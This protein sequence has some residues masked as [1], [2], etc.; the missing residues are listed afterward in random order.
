MK[1]TGIKDNLARSLNIVQH[2]L[3]S[4][5]IQPIL[6]GI[7]LS[8]KNGQLTMIATDI[9]D[10]VGMRIQCSVPINVIEEGDT[11]VEGKQF[12][13][14]VTRLPD[15]NII[16][17]ND[18]YNGKDTM[19][20][21]YGNN[22]VTMYGFPGYEF[23]NEPKMELTHHLAMSAQT[24]S[25]IVRQT[26]FAVKKEDLRPIFTGL[27]FEVI[28]NELTVVG[29]DSFRLALMK[30]KINNLTGE[31][32]QVVI[33]VRALQEVVSIAEEDAIINISIAKNQVIFEM[34]N[35]RLM[36]QLIKGEF[37]P[38]KGA[39]PNTHTTFFSIERATIKQSLERATL[40]SKDRTGT[41]VVRWIV[42]NGKVDIKTES[43]IGKVN[44]EIDVFIEGDAVNI[45]FNANFLMD[46]L[47]K[48][49]YDALDIELSGDL[50]PCIIRPKNDESYL[51][52]L[53]PLRQ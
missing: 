22:Q 19:T 39:I 47:T 35:V 48:I 28:G 31:D 15:T 25:D 12:R 45:C 10:D 20:I 5:S 14:F 7:Y 41:S 24:L 29:T 1:F 38:Y 26:S 37:P 43:E 13:D 23:P 33:P 44:E 9:S 3:S 4:K 16:F 36:T 6:S 51:Y 18:S 30:D 42:E 17:D 11:V 21:T 52:L 40:F 34:D 46:A 49:H 32:I 2:A 50:G 53:L 27:S 8:C